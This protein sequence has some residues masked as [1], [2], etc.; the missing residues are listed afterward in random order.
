MRVC[1]IC[2]TAYVDNT[3]P[4]RCDCGQNV[5]QC[6]IDDMSPGEYARLTEP[7]E[8]PHCHGDGEVILPASRFGNGATAPCPECDGAGLFPWNA[9]RKAT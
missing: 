8:C 1:V 9:T 4:G 7:V 3:P 2:Q 6:D 5:R